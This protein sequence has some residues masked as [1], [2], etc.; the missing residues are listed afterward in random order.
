MF[1][2][3]GPVRRAL[4]VCV[5]A[6][7]GALALVAAAEVTFS[8]AHSSIAA[9]VADLRGVACMETVE[10]TR[11]APRLPAGAT[12][13]QIV[14]GANESPGSLQWRSRLRLNVLAG[15]EGEEF[16]LTD[17]RRFEKT[18]IGGILAAAAQGSGEFSAFLSKTIAADPSLFQ[19]RGS[20]QTS[21]GPLTAFAFTLP[22]AGGPAQRGALF[23]TS[24]TGDLRR[25]TLESENTGG[26][27]LVRYTTDYA[28]ARIGD[29]YV[30]VPRN[31]TMEAF[32]KDG[33]ERRST[34]YFSGCRRPDTA[35]ASAAAPATDT[36]A[37][38]PPPI[39]AGTRFRV[40]I[41][42]EIQATTAATGDPVVGVIRSTV[43][44]KQKEIIVHSGDR[45]HGRIALIEEYLTPKPHWNVAIVFETIERG[46]GVNGIYQGVEQP[47]SI[48]PSEEA[49][50]PEAQKLRPPNGNYYTLTGANPVLDQDEDWEVR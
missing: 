48:A 8:K 22:A 15:A 35:A 16:S 17:A 36:P 18:D 21:I 13:A 6:A 50:S 28:T 49:S 42:P 5:C 39:P 29:R 44:N 46:V 9:D 2:F 37:A 24:D 23:V 11:Y 43:K 40:R 25:L 27:C 38:D 31:S 20:Q 1:G 34:S 33:S 12:C 7:I 14:A 47:V 41:D 26:A 4:P 19:P 45:L 3:Q 10:R 30:L 32:L